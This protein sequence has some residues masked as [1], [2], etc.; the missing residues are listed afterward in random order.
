MNIQQN[1]IQALL[2]VPNLLSC[3]RFVAAPVLLWLA[4]QG[5]SIAFLV[6]LAV[7]FLSDALDGLAARLTGQVTLLGAKLDSWADVITYLTIA[8]SCW[9]LWPE[10]VKRE[11]VFVALVI[12]SYLLPAIIGIA[13]F[14]TFTSYHTWSVKLAAAAMGFSLYVLFLGGPAWP[15]RIASCLCIIAAIEEIAISMILT[16]P[17][18]NISSIRDV[19]QRTS[20]QQT[21]EIDRSNK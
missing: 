14:G 2:T 11:I 9:W 1:Q 18:S 12:T 17:R 3:F 5:S 8:I 13:K 21:S 19:L 10:V 15:F 16:V 6:L 7:V 4:W 20:Q